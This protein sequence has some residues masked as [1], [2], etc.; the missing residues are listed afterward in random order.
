[1]TKAKRTPGPWI[2][3]NPG[4]GNLIR[5][6]HGVCI[7]GDGTAIRSPANAAFIVRACNVHEELLAALQNVLEW[8]KGSR[9]SKNT[10]PYGVPE[11]EA[12]LKVLAKLQG[13]TDWLDAN[14][15]A[16]GGGNDCECDPTCAICD[17][18]GHAPHEH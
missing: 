11:V 10:N 8:A 7:A 16:E 6:S 17:E 9:G 14:T 3:I 13:R 2:H 4:Q 12:A 5:D 15:K 1:M 18:P